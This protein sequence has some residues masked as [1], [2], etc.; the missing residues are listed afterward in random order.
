MNLYYNIAGMI[1]S[2]QKKTAIFFVANNACIRTIT[3]AF[4]TA[5]F[6]CDKVEI[7][8]TKCTLSFFV[9]SSKGKEEGTVVGTTASTEA[10]DPK[11]EEMTTGTEAVDSTVTTGTTVVDSVSMKENSEVLSL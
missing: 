5:I 7:I 8:S 9:L 6:R 2:K 4:T 3:G 1:V 10:E 11:S